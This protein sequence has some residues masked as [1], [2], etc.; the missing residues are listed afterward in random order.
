MATFTSTTKV[1]EVLA[2]LKGAGYKIGRSMLF[3]HAK[4]GRLAR[5]KTGAFTPEAIAEFAR[6]WLRQETDLL[7]EAAEDAS[8]AEQKAEAMLALRETQA[9][10]AKLRLDKQLARMVPMA[11]IPPLLL[12]RK[13]FLRR[14]F[15]EALERHLPLLLAA[16]GVEAER[17]EVVRAWCITMVEALLAAYGAPL[18]IKPLNL[19]QGDEADEHAAE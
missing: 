10:R 4:A 15:G 5:D 2:Q 19:D 8:L 9:A 17:G 13:R 14:E 6:T 1:P 12:A 7:A 11:A 16:M 3:E 18:R